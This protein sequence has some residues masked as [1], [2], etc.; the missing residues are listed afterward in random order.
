MWAIDGR[1]S[2]IRFGAG[3]QAHKYP[4]WLERLKVFILVPTAMSE[5]GRWQVEPTAAAAA[6]LVYAELY[7]NYSHRCICRWAINIVM[8]P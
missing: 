5:N 7:L 6:A 1:F 3:V 4:R 8:M 2:P